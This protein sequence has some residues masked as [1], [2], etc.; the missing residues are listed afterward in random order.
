M[1]PTNLLDMMIDLYS[2][3]GNGGMST[4]ASSSCGI[5]PSDWLPVWFDPKVF[6]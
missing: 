1:L 2:E 3:D 5:C 4:E 6:R